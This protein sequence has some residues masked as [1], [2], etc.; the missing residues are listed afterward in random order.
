MFLAR[1]TKVL[2]IVALSA[3][4]VLASSA[5]VGAQG[6]PWT[7][8]AT[9]SALTEAAMVYDP[10]TDLL[11]AYGGRDKLITKSSDPSDA[12]LVLDAGLEAGKWTDVT[13]SV[14]GI[15]GPEVYGAAGVYFPTRE[16]IVFFG[17]KGLGDRVIALDMS[18][19]VR[20][21]RWVEPRLGGSMPARRS[22]SAVYVPS[23]DGMLVFG[24]TLGNDKAASDT[25]DELVLITSNG[26]GFNRR[27]L[28]APFGPAP[29]YD[30]TA[31]YDPVNQI[32]IVYGGQ[33]TRKSTAYSDV[34]GLDL[35]EP[36]SP[37]WVNLGA[38]IEGDTAGG[39]S[40]HTAVYDPLRQQMV[41]FGGKGALAKEIWALNLSEGIDGP[42][43]VRLLAGDAPGAPG[44]LSD[45]TAAWVPAH[46]YMVVYGGSARGTEVSTTWMY[47][48]VDTEGHNWRTDPGWACTAGDPDSACDARLAT[49][50]YVD[51]RCD[52]FYSAGFDRLLS[53]ATVEVA[54]PAE[55]RTVSATTDAQG[56]AYFEGLTVPAGLPLSLNIT[57][58]GA[59]QVCGYRS[60]M[61]EV[62]GARFG[63]D[64][65]AAV[66]IG[67]S[68]A[69]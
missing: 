27:V 6:A 24:G 34:W 20:G 31:I 58:E 23:L 60:N 43:W 69:P 41:V 3:A 13:G 55:S 47:H 56:V 17:G 44:A 14:A 67:L 49:R 10:D 37:R 52:G 61:L 8:Y 26:S 22:H 45:H 15:A 21:M 68:P 19:G 63:L 2:A 59:G 46:D 7:E 64:R 30:H 12:V 33:L 57:H 48:P 9:G 66:S 65:F 35:R 51:V 16:Q 40:A 50:V 1:S 53:G 42:T 62:S 36:T 11:V 54:V 38:R 4:F 28:N 29:R 32:M 39:R 25:L 5:T 18:A